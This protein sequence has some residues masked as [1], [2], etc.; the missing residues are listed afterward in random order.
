VQGALTVFV[1]AGSASLSPVAGA[2]GRLGMMGASVSFLFLLAAA[3][4]GQGAPSINNYIPVLNDPL[5]YA[6][7]ALLGA[8]VALPILRLLIAV[9]RSR[10]TEPMTFGVA[11]AGA[12]FLIAL[13]CF[14]LA[15][16][17]QPAGFDAEGLNEYLMWGGGHILQFVNTAL[18][19]CSLY[20]LSRVA[21]GE[22]PLAPAFFKV[23]MLLLVAGAAVG[24]LVYATL[25]AGDPSQ[26]FMFTA[27]YRYALPLPTTIVCVSVIML[28]IR[29]RMDIWAG[30]PELRGLA[31]ALVLFAWGGVMGYFE[32]SVDT[33]TPAHYHAVLIAVTLMFM[34]VTFAVFLPML[35]RRNEHRRLRTAMYLML[36]IGTLVQTTGLFAAGLMGVARKTAGTAQG[37]DTPAKLAS[38]L[39]N[40]TGG[41][42]AAI[43]GVI[44]IVLAAKMLLAKPRWGDTAAHPMSPGAA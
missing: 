19:L 8:S 22:T 1:T 21:F 24:P 27:L 40:L 43:G 36:G 9:A 35:E 25:P 11:A 33:R 34:A 3:L 16:L 38:L 29:R 15:W 28:L 6:G 14:A 7:L 37:L 17:Q 2:I 30:V 5:Y 32:S 31:A 39:V 12:M 41:V 4:A 18:F 20:L 23:L 42:I 10:H 44:F 26:R 13:G